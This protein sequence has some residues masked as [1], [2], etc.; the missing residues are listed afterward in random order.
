MSWRNALTAM[1]L[2]GQALTAGNAWA[3]SGMSGQPVSNP[4]MAR[5]HLGPLSLAPTVALSNFGVDSN[6]FNTGGTAEPTSDVIASVGPAVDGWVR[7]SRVRFS[8][9]T[10]LNYVYFRELSDLR[11]FQHSGRRPRGSPPEPRDTLG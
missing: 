4:D 3:Q 5:V 9:R 2:I 11:S 6:V 1:T 10:E 8:G 7:L